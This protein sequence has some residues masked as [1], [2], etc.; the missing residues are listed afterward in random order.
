LFEAQF[1][2]KFWDQRVKIIKGL[3]IKNA[4]L[5]ISCDFMHFAKTEDIWL[6]SALDGKSGVLLI[7]EESAGSKKNSPPQLS[8]EGYKELG[9]V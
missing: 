1:L 8:F 4:K 5:Q 2:E 6:K 7:T 9:L 3:V